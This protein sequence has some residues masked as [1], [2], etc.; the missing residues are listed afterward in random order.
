MLRVYL[1]GP[2]FIRDGNT[3][4]ERMKILM[5]YWENFEFNHQLILAPLLSDT[6]QKEPFLATNA[7]HERVFL[8]LV[9]RVIQP[10]HFYE[11]GAHEAST[12]I[13]V[14]KK[15]PTSTCVAFE[16]DPDIHAHFVSEYAAKN[17]PPNFS[18]LQSA[19][20]D[21]DG[22]AKFQKQLEIDGV[23]ASALLPNNSLKQKN[24]G[25]R[26]REVST[27]CMRMDTYVRLHG[28]VE[29]VV[30]R[31]DVEGLCYE[32]LQGAL[33]LLNNCAAVYAEVEDY[34]IWNGQK[35]VFDIYPVLEQCGFVPVSRD[36]QTPGQYNVLWL[37]K[38][39]AINRKFRS[40]LSIYYNEL[41]LICRNLERKDR[42]EK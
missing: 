3:D 19:V 40:R 33:H 22:E 17:V 18:Y 12:A 15:L 20:A 38:Q 11:I 29:K 13:H 7:C 41:M 24:I 37:R 39:D 14:A 32:V 6:T 26:Y 23:I 34:E 36:V 2:G 8:D 25:I 42:R 9:T 5:T 30:L 35:T 31:I 1:T 10:T 21:Y 16:A 28:P 27:P 4:F